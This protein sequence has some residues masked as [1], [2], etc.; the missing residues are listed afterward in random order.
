M[1]K[2]NTFIIGAPKCGTTSLARWLAEHPQVFFSNPKEPHYFNT[3]FG[4]K[5]YES[6]GEYERLFSRANDNHRAV[7]EGTVRYLYSKDA[8]PNIIEYA[9]NPKFIVMTRDP[10]AMATSLHNQTIFNGDE[11]KIDFETAWRRQRSRESG[12]QIPKA[13]RDPQLLQYGELCKLG[14]QMERLLEQ[15]SASSVHVIP[16]EHLQKNPASEWKRVL[17]FLELDDDGRTSFP[18][19]NT[20]KKRR[21]K[22][23]WWALETANRTAKKLNIPPIRLGLTQVAH[24]RLSKPHSRPPLNSATRADLERFFAEDQALLRRIMKQEFG[25]DL[26]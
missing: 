11:D 12:C 10:V 23:A 8:V 20:S 3:D 24:K 6:I 22:W 2:P 1:K 17:E 15:V 19:E 26:P 21:F 16:L 7:C 9:E 13:C 4:P 18:A 14:K 5:K 25:R